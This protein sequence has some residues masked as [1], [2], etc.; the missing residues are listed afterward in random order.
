MNAPR[1]SYRS[2]AATLAV[3]V[4]P[5]CCAAAP[6]EPFLKLD[7]LAVTAGAPFRLT[8]N[9]PE[10]ESWAEANIA[11]LVLRTYGRHDQVTIP[12]AASGKELNAS[13][14]LP[15]PTMLILSAG[16]AAEKG[17]SDSWQRTP[18]CAKYFLRVDP[19]PDAPPAA[20]TPA[21]DPGFCGKV[22]QKIELLPGMS[23]AALEPGSDMIVRAYYEGEAQEGDAVTAYRPDGTSE[24]QLT[25][26]KG[27]AN[28]RITQGGRWLIRYTKVADGEKYTADL[29]FD[30]PGGSQKVEAERDARGEGGQR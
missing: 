2:V 29:V 9:L 10:G 17:K 16:P 14:P 22:G 23:P 3:W 27:F 1:D 8:L 6:P 20:A 19:A 4:V 12:P 30:V 28:F 18:Y 15:G 5:V 25:R 26:S 7:S 13:V 11:Q 24:I 21:P